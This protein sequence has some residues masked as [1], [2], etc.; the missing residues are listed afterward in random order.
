MGS[1]SYGD[2]KGVEDI[3]YWEFRDAP[4]LAAQFSAEGPITK[5]AGFVQPVA[6][7]GDSRGES[8][9]NAE[10]FCA[11]AQVI[12]NAG[13]AGL[14][15]FHHLSEPIQS[16]AELTS[17]LF[18]L[19]GFGGVSN[20]V[21]SLILGTSGGVSRVVII[22]DLTLSVNTIS[23]SA[24]AFGGVQWLAPLSFTAA[25]PAI[26]DTVPTLISPGSSF[27]GLGLVYPKV[28]ARL[29][30]GRRADQSA[31]PLQNNAGAVFGSPGAMGFTATA[32][33]AQPFRPFDRA[34]PFVLMPGHGFAIGW[35]TF[36]VGQ[37]SNVNATC[38]V[39]WKEVG[40]G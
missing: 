5:V 30:A 22:L 11:S 35:G 18:G 7:V 3:P 2:P 19:A 12:A 23:N 32:G 13:D 33:Q 25:S 6:I 8:D 34:T 28:R 29:W 36:G 1:R 4:D 39:I 14:F 31:L 27:S 40:V 38:S 24:G 16:L 26:I 10:I 9:V 21:K 15:E 17:I 20:A 37:Q